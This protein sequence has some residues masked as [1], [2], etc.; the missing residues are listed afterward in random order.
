[1]LE[2]LSV[3]NFAL[4][5]SLTLG[6][7]NGFSVLTG[8][9]GAGKSIIVGSISFLLGAKAD[10]EV[11]RSGCDEAAVSAVVTV[12]PQNRDAL[13]WLASRDIAADDGSVIVRR[14]VKS[15]GRSSIYIQNVPVT[16]GD[17]AEFMALLFDLHGQ[18][19]HETLL[20]KETHRKYL[21]R[22]AGLEDEALAFNKVFMELSDK[23]KAL[24]SS[25]SSERDR[26]ARLEI[27]N[28]GVDEVT[29]AN[30]KPGEIKELETEA[31]RLGDFEKLSLQ[32]N[33]AAEAFFDGE[34]SLLSLARHTRTGMDNA[35]SIDASL[36]PLLK[37]MEDLFYEAE[38]LAGEFRSY[39]D[40]LSYDPQRLEEVEDRLA[41]L[42]KLKKKY[43]PSGARENAGA[44]ESLLTWKTEAEAEIEALTGAEEN[45]D[46]LRGEISALEKSIA[47]RA[48]ALSAKRIEGAK[49]LGRGIS[50]ILS[51]L[52][53]PNAKFEASV[54]AKM[55]ERASLLC[56]P[57]GADD[58]EFLISANAGEPLKEL[59]RIAS[60][61]ELSRVMLAIKTVL[62]G[63]AKGEAASDANAET[64]IFDEI[65]TG[66]G[67]EVALSVGEYL[68]QIG[69]G[70]QIFCVTHL[71]SIAVRADNH[72][73]VEKRV[74]A[75]EGGGRTV[76]GVSLLKPGE[77]RQEIARML[78][79]EG[80]A[81]ALAHADELL[82]KYGR[83]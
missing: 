32:V 11:I 8:E 51:R 68:A 56:G 1:M 2:E 58:V 18:H 42:H 37:R 33:S 44:E 69:K 38:D 40:S 70:K 26:D 54:T 46:K 16:R 65:D 55:S 21:D 71:A 49:K 15:S 62:A 4:V 66:I 76:T 22:F 63:E 24:E 6:F 67:G 43:V 78:A 59:A 30:P 79:G 28:Y 20:H 47:S 36:Q 14:A 75:G 77:R 74:I 39:R 82:A 45:R 83:S 29:K 10:A 64:L 27:L 13:G 72:L 41:L 17:L 12:A 80:G 52:G 73:K 34:A 57:W 53:M 61:G 9:T 25:L 35:A 7:E 3:R 50:S 31:Q 19:T 60:G 5:D 23:R 48:S 81:A